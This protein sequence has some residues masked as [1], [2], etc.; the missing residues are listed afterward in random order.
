MIIPIGD[1]N[2]RKT[3]PFI[4]YL[5]IAANVAVFV[6]QFTQPKPETF[7]E[8]YA[9]YPAHYDWKTLFTSMFMHAGIAHLF[10][11]MLFLWIAGDNVEDRVGHLAYLVFYLAAGAAGGLA[12][13]ATSSGD[14]LGVPTVGASGAISGVIGAYLIFFPTSRIKFLVLF[15]M[16]TFTSPS[17]V[18]IGLWIG[19]QALLIKAQMDGKGTNIAVF[20]HAGGFALGVVLSIL[21]RL[22][23]SR[24]KKD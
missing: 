16:A 20:A 10:G 11:N 1:T 7:I 14:M 5:L 15:F 24:K 12:H 22:F 8:V 6:W 19:T 3:V 21:H 18:A 13:I 23:V 2:P 17:W 9:L 4:N